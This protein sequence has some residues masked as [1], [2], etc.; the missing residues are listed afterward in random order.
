MKTENA[1]RACE[2]AGGTLVNKEPG[3]QILSFSFPGTTRLVEF[4]DE[5]GTT[6]AIGFRDADDHNDPY[7]DYCA[8][9]FVSSI[10]RAIR[11]VQYSA[12]PNPRT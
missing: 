12:T 11:L 7:T 10:A 8:T 9:I 4:V 3:S 2:R 5:G 1:I 6:T